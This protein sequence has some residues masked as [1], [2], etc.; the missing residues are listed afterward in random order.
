M[1]KV[2]M[3]DHCSIAIADDEDLCPKCKA[4]YHQHCRC[5]KFLHTDCEDE[6]GMCTPCFSKLNK[7]EREEMLSRVNKRKLDLLDAI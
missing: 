3:M 7:S 6:R 2:C 1:S 4:Y 5:G